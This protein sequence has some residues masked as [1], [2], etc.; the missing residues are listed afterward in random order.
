MSKVRSVMFLLVFSPC[1]TRLQF[2]AKKHHLLVQRALVCTGFH[3]TGRNCCNALSSSFNCPSLTLMLTAS[4]W[5]ILVPPPGCIALHLITLKMHLRKYCLNHPSWPAPGNTESHQ[6]TIGKFLGPGG[7]FGEVGVLRFFVSTFTIRL[8]WVLTMN[9]ASGEI[10]N[11]RFDFR[12]RKKRTADD[13]CIDSYSA[14]V[15]G[16]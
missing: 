15:A 14:L 6:C 10:N 13:V 16:S 11:L 5:C 1:A 12:E 8:R 9:I 7:I 4:L 2:P 3:Q